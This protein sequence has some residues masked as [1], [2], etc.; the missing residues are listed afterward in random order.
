MK[1]ENC[2]LCGDDTTDAPVERLVQV[3][4]GLS[5]RNI[6]LRLTVYGDNRICASCWDR[7]VNKMVKRME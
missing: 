5:G 3:D 4:A 2:S 6:Y 1:H 7:I